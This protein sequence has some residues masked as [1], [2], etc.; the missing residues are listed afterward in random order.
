[1]A[2][3]IL[4]H[5]GSRLLSREGLFT[6]WSELFGEI[7]RKNNPKARILCFVSRIPQVVVLQSYNAPPPPL[8]NATLRAN[9]MIK[10]SKKNIVIGGERGGGCCEELGFDMAREKGYPSCAHFVKVTQDFYDYFIV[11]WSFCRYHW[12]EDAC[13]SLINSRKMR[14]HK[15]SKLSCFHV[16]LVHLSHGFQ[17]I[18]FSRFL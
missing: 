16:D 3:P 15:D 4:T 2:I 1:M 12:R 8:K 11:E 17:S 14:L 7:L 5:R 13:I 18:S 9:E 6:L 10:L